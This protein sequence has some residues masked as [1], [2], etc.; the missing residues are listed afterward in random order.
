M[1]FH[2]K[3]FIYYFSVSAF[4]L[5][6]FL[7]IL[8]G[9]TRKFLPSLEMYV[10]LIF[11]GYIYLV[12]MFLVLFLKLNTVR[13][14]LV[15]LLYIYL[16]S[17]QFFADYSSFI[18]FLL[19]FKSLV[20]LFLYIPIIQYLMESDSNFPTKIEKHIK[21]IFFA[22]LLVWAF[23]FMA[24]YI[25]HPYYQHAYEWFLSLCDLGNGMT[26]KYSRPIG[27]TLNT[28]FQA[29]IFASAA[30]YYFIYKKY[31]FV[32]IF[33]FALFITAVKT[34]IIGL[35]LVFVL[36]FAKNIS[37]FNLKYLLMTFIMIY[38]VSIF[39]NDQVEH[40]K[41]QT[42]ISSYGVQTMSGLWLGSFDVMID[43]IIPYGF[44]TEKDRLFN[45]PHTV[46][47]SGDAFLIFYTYTIGTF[48][49]ILY[50]LITYYTILK[51]SIYT[52]IV[53]LSLFAM[54]HT[55]PMQVVGIFIMVLYFSMYYIVENRK[56]YPA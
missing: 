33:L 22:A 51:K 16:L 7:P 26:L 3:L 28:H 48:G 50:V 14:L 23:E 40:Y 43:S 15:G 53:F 25:A 9:I 56:T 52:P 2:K 46:R 21:V 36:F 12:P 55:N 20:L 30:I 27:I 6:I 49:A 17:T 18:G 35:A 10:Q 8:T 11:Q 38:V 1:I 4:Y 24:R 45:L 31:Y 29:M 47:D 5:S 41:S 54:I 42:E 34:W 32:F 39:F 13:M 37:R 44:T 19:G